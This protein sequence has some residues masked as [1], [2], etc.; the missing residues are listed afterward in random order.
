[1]V[2]RNT[3]LVLEI[4][5]S[6]ETIKEVFEV[7]SGN[8]FIKHENME[9]GVGNGIKKITVSQFDLMRINF[10]AKYA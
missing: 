5:N 6:F 10:E 7:G 8:Y 9:G 3:H 2:I 4:N 1:M